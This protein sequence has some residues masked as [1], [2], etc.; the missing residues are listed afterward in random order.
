MK[1]QAKDEK[2]E[3]NDVEEIFERAFFKNK[4]VKHISFPNATKIGIE[5]FAGCLNLESVDLPNVLGIWSG[6]FIGCCNLKSYNIPKLNSVP[7]EEPIFTND[8]LPDELILGKI[9]FKYQKNQEHFENEYVTVV[10]NEAFKN[11]KY[12]KSIKLKNVW[13]IGN[14][15]FSGA[16]KL[17]TLE[18]DSYKGVIPYKCKMR[19]NMNIFLDEFLKYNF[20]LKEIKLSPELKIPNIQFDW[21]YTSMPEVVHINSTLVKCSTKDE[22][23]IDNEAYFVASNAFK[24]NIYVNKIYL[25]N[26][27]FC[28]WNSFCGADSIREIHIPNWDNKYW[29]YIK[30]TFRYLDHI[31]H[32]LNISSEVPVN[33]I[34]IPG[35]THN[36]C[37]K[38]TLMENS[39]QDELV[40]GN[41]LLYYKGDA[42]EYYNESIESF[43]GMLLKEADNLEKIHLPNL[44]ELNILNTDFASI[45]NLKEFIIDNPSLNEDGAEAIS[46]QLM[47]IPSLQKFQINDKYSGAKINDSWVI[48]SKY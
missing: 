27:K 31:Q 3:L 13:S 33:V 36:I 1:Y 39:A 25:E 45:T 26:V 12:I 35:F 34:D 37:F 11:N 22:T 17:E 19:E 47:K 21:E 29:E 43:N 14:E 10:A 46:E 4:Y 18:L 9:L 8:F 41:T 44:K 30:S 7:N 16:V 24:N 42:K 28:N 32:T 38:N 2:V 48:D 15:A 5:A 6:A 23:F 20:S 40:V